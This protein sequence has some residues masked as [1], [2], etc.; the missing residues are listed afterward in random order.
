MLG[1]FIEVDIIETYSQ[2]TDA[3]TGEILYLE[4]IDYQYN[5][6]NV[7]KKCGNLFSFIGRSTIF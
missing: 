4:S 1:K 6:K 2:N 7:I 3:L 5:S